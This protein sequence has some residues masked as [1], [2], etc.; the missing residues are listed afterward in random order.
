MGYELVSKSYVVDMDSWQFYKVT[1]SM[2]LPGVRIPYYMEQLRDGAKLSNLFDQGKR[3][4][5]VE[6]NGFSVEFAEGYRASRRYL[7]GGNQKAIIRHA[8]KELELWIRPKISYPRDGRVKAW[9]S[10]VNYEFDDGSRKSSFSTLHSGG[11]RHQSFFNIQGLVRTKIRYQ[12]EDELCFGVLPTQYDVLYKEKQL[13]GKCYA[14]VL[15]TWGILLD[16]DLSLDSVVILRGA[17]QSILNVE[18]FLYTVN[19]Y[20]MKFIV[21][22]K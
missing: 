7:F 16:D 3:S 14:L 6:L 9:I 21:L 4:M 10:D 5:A 17:S 12:T 18:K 15:G 1:G 2:D 11:W 8:G 19:S 20:V 22:A 13:G